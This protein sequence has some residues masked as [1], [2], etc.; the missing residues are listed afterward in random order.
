MP[1]ALT[2]LRV[3]DLAQ[4][5]AG[6]YATKLLA[7]NGA[8]VGY[9]EPARLNPRVVLVSVSNFGQ[10]GPFSQYEGSE[11]TLFAIGAEMHS[12]G[13]LGREPGEA[14]R[15]VDAPPVRRTRRGRRHGG[16]HGFFERMRH[17]DLGDREWPAMLYDMSATRL[18]IR[19]PPVGL[20]ED[21]THVYRDLLGMDDA[22]WQALVAAGEIAR[23]YGED[24]P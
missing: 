16:A 6:P 15:H 20:G 13:I 4:H 3:L 14:A 21:N 1:S 10:T 22:G 8:D 11:L 2:G 9:D 18:S 5:I 17:P 24:I 12:V 19:K 23:D 7:D